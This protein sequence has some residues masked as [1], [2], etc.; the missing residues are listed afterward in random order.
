M[1]TAQ[2][3]EAIRAGKTRKALGL[4]VRVSADRAGAEGQSPLEVAAALGRTRV[5]Q[6]LLRRG[7]DADG[8]A[9]QRPPLCCAAGAGKHEVVQLLLQGGAAVDCACGHGWTPLFSAVLGGHRQAAGVLLRHGADAGRADA[10]GRTPLMA[11][12]IAGDRRMVTA[13]LEHGADAAYESPFG[14]SALCAA[15]RMGHVGLVRLLEQRGAT[16]QRVD[17][18][19]LEPPGVQRLRGEL[20]ELFR[21]ETRTFPDEE[22]AGN[23]SRLLNHLMVHLGLHGIDDHWRRLDPGACLQLLEHLLTRDL[24]HDAP[25]HDAAS[26]RRLAG[27]LL[28]LVR[29][30]EPE[31]YTSAGWDGERVGSWSSVGGAT[32]EV[33][34]V[35]LGGPRAVILYTGQED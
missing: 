30:D 3:L 27:D 28:D 23:R 15:D 4:L 6:E 29:P 14:E 33:A 9:G 24:V 1:S 11:A 35:I 18:L 19:P 22:L 12:V 20:G 7:A 34:V 32:F 25:L 5:V 31:P 16:L 26:A 10:D 21:L 2:L 17:F 8:P 13:L